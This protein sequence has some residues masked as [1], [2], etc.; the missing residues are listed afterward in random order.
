MT[1]IL[2]WGTGSRAKINYKISK[3]CRILNNKE[4][5]GFIDNNNGK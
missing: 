1:K 3:N 5:I 2:I 4:I